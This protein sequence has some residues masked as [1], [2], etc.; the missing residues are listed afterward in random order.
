MLEDVKEV[1]S[2]GG[3]TLAQGA[4]A[5]IW[6]RSPNTIPIPGFKTVKQAEENAKAMAFGPLTQDQMRQIETILKR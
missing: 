2:S 3:R 5:W 4:L 6:G 1:L